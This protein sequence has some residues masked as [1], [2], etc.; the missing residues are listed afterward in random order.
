MLDC[1]R[2]ENQPEVKEKPKIWELYID[3]SSSKEES[4]AGLILVEL[5]NQKFEYALR[6]KFPALN[7]KA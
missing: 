7:N 2:K 4:G 6:F 3:K 5:E 1:Y